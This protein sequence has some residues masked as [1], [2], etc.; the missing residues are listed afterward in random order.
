MAFDDLKPQAPRTA[1]NSREPERACDY[2]EHALA[3]SRAAAARCRT[4]LD[5]AFGADYY[6]KLDVYLPADAAARGL[7]VMLFFHGGAWA[8][9][10][11]EWNGFMAPGL[12]EMPA[13]FVSASYRLVPE[14]KFPAALDDAFAA[15]AWVRNNIV[16]HGGDPGRIHVAGW[17][18]GGTLASLITL[19]RELYREHG[20]PGDTVKACFPSS[21]TFQIRRDAPA[22]GS[23]G[24]DYAQ[25][26]LERPQDDAAASPINYV[27]GNRTPFFISHGSEDFP[28]VKRS[29]RA[30]VRALEGAGAPVLYRVYD[31]ADHYANNLATQDA[32]HD[33]M[34]TVR[35]WMSGG[36]P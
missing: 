13:V 5:I 2:A 10:Y 36:T 35:G 25:F 9:G 20:L 17:S 30:M 33:W 31:G 14:H 4:A 34:V 23:R 26:L 32:D 6:Q 29:S 3:L 19:R 12:V 11:K 27:R 8:H 18:A 7:P 28:H 22:P 16:H 24:I 15:L 21:S 1:E